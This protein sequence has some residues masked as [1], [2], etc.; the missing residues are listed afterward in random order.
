VTLHPTRRVFL[1][2]GLAGSCL[3]G[4]ALSRPS[5]SLGQPPLV[6]TTSIASGRRIEFGAE[7]TTVTLALSTDG[8][9]ERLRQ[10]AAPNSTAT[11]LLNVEGVEFEQH[12]GTTAEIYL[13]LPP[14]VA[15]SR[16]SLRFVGSL[17]FFGP[18][19]TDAPSRSV[20]S[21]DITRLVKTLRARGLWN[22]DRITV[23]FA[24]ARW[25][26]PGGGV[27]PLPQDVRVRI[28]QVAIVVQ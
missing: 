1:K 5:I 18:G 21:Y 17:A 14:G 11:I 3:G 13:N 4:L 26:R 23:T 24:L 10:A 27:E 19:R 6:T 28:A 7:P 20:E 25:T 16:R 9:R 22:D 8:A 2:A 15:P 12:P